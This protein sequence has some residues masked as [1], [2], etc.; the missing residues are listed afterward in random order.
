MAKYEKEELSEDQNFE[1]DKLSEDGI[2]P[3]DYLFVIG[4]D[5]KMKSVIFPAE[6]SVF[7]HKDLLKLFAFFGIDNPDD[8][9]E[10]RTL[11]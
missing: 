2:E 1:E 11:H 4:S 6:D 5:G 10:S 9:L 7:Y 8:L 3:D